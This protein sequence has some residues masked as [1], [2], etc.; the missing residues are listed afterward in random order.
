MRTETSWRNLR[1]QLHRRISPLCFRLPVTP[2]ADAP[3]AT[4]GPRRRRDHRG[5]GAVASAGGG[6]SCVCVGV[7]GRMARGGMG[8]FLNR[9]GHR[10]L[11]ENEERR[12]DSREGEIL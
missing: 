11:T 7:V 4:Q 1:A 3:A 2:S 12:K 8:C 6:S 9:F 10:N 5:S